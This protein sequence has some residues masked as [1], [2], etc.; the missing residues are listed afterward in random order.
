MKAVLFE[1]SGLENL[2]VSEVKDPE[3]GPHEVVLRVIESGVNPID[4]FVVV[5]IPVKPVPH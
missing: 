3:P 2:K 1:K 5:G 4:Y